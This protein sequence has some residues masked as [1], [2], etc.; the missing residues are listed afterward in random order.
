VDHARGA[1]IELPFDASI[2]WDPSHGGLGLSA[3]GVD[4]CEHVGGVHVR[5]EADVEPGLDHGRDD[6]EGFSAPIR[7][8]VD[9]RHVE[10]GDVA[11]IRRHAVAAASGVTALGLQELLLAIAEPHGAV[12]DSHQLLHRRAIDESTSMASVAVSR[13]LEPP[14]QALTVEDRIV[15]VLRGQAL[16]REVNRAR[17][18]KEDR[19]HRERER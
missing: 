14:G 17:G 2:A 7:V 18:E 4:L 15:I 13:H 12:D 3:P 6:I 11:Q 16:A 8:A 1:S 9:F 10:R 5:R 19:P